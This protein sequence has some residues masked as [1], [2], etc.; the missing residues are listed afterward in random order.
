VGIGHYMIDLHPSVT[1]HNSLY[2][3]AT[4]FRVPLGTL[5]PEFGPMN[6]LAA[7]KCLSVTHIA[8]GATR[9]HPTEWTV[10]ETP[11]ALACFCLERDHEPAAVLAKRER[12]RDFQSDLVRD[13]F[14]LAWPWEKG[15]NL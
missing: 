11:G 13:G 15:K 7:G 3:Q 2:I 14:E 12:L 6:L 9:L 10:G 1:M 5:V 8:N 4:P